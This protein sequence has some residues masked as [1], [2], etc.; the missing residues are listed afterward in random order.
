MS[1]LVS[2]FRSPR[3]RMPPSAPKGK[4]FMVRRGRTD[5]QGPRG[6]RGTRGATGRAGPRGTAGKPGRR[7]LKGATQQVRV[8]DVLDLLV[9][10]F[11]DVYREL[12]LQMKKIAKIQDQLDVMAATL[13]TRTGR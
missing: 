3:S 10:H 5:A 1:V 9:T 7:G 2:L 4:Q 11:D 13:G 6:P 12:N 8:K